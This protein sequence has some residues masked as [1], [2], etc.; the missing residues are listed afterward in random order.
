[1][2]LRTVQIIYIKEEMAM[3]SFNRITTEAILLTFLVK[4]SDNYFVRETV[5]ENIIVA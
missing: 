5:D 2:D 1:M 3:L 4:H